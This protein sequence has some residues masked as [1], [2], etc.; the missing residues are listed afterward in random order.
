MAVRKY[1]A[2]MLHSPTRDSTMELSILPST[3]PETALESGSKKVQ[4]E[5]H[6]PSAYECY[7]ILREGNAVPWCEWHL[8]IDENDKIIKIAEN[9]HRDLKKIKPS[10]SIRDEVETI[11]K[12]F[13][14]FRPK[15]YQWNTIRSY[16][17]QAR[18]D[19]NPLMIIK[20]Y[21]VAQEFTSYINNDS[22]ANTYHALKLYCTMLSC[23][24]RAQTQEYTEAIT[25]ILF[26]PKLDALLVQEEK[27]VYRGIWLE[28]KTLVDNYEEGATIITTTFLST[29]TNPEM[30]DI[31]G[32]VRSDDTISIS[33]TY[34]LNNTKR[35]SAL[36]LGR[37]S[38]HPDEE[39]ILI[40]RYVPFTIKS[41]ERSDDG[42]RMKICFDECKDQ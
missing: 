28:D 4:R 24:I 16:F 2:T 9:F 32:P 39:E 18:K 21:T 13:L 14:E 10:S 15:N 22:A 23:P 34:H 12:T 29:S 33:C 25:N 37:N 42:R 27:I 1:L 40:L 6:C 38:Q 26:H 20:A 3:T 5:F 8:T 7:N 36:N 17:K 30:A 11:Q 31:Y 35:R 41:L 19:D